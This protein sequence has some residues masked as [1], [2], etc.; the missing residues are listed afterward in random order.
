MKYLIIVPEIKRTGP[1]NVVKNLIDTPTFKKHKI[2]IISL[3]PSKDINFLHEIISIEN[4]EVFDSEIYGLLKRLKFFFRIVNKIKPDVIHSHGFYP[5]VFSCFIVGGGK[6]ISTIHNIIYQDYSLRYGFKGYLFSFIHYFFLK[7]G[8]FYKIFG[9]SSEVSIS[10][11]KIIKTPNIEFVNNGIN[12]KYFSSLNTNEKLELKRAL[13]FENKIIISFCGGVE[14]VK[15]VP[16]LVDQYI[17][18]LDNLDFIFLIIGDGPELNKIK[19]S[20]KIVKLGRVENPYK[21]LRISDIV[22][23]N[24]SS[25]GYPMA[26]LEAL[27]SGNKVFLS[28]IPSHNSIIGKYPNCAFSIKN[29]K[30]DFILKVLTNKLDN[31]HLYSIS[32]DKMA[33]D[34]LHKL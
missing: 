8:K 3:R 19:E 14:R 31:S 6:K 20:N 25:E 11:K 12:I 4:V 7:F 17:S 29:L 5:D 10:L 21:Y 26:I 32:S 24:S 34:Y 16:E 30:K 23:S 9:C 18:K 1:I 13:G 22:V 27:S 15:R 28:D 33:N 2:F